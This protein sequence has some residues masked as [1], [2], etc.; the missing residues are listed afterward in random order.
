MVSALAAPPPHSSSSLRY[1]HCSLLPSLR[2]ALKRQFGETSLCKTLSSWHSLLRFPVRHSSEHQGNTSRFCSPSVSRAPRA[3]CQHSPGQV[4]NVQLR[5]GE[6]ALHRGSLGLKQERM[7]GFS[8]INAY[9][10]PAP[11]Y[12]NSSNK[13]TEM[14]AGFST[15]THH[16]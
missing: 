10:L 15:Q 12:E 1:T 16:F 7:P 2:S 8:Y 3:P 6:G 13:S 9:I 4:V 5:A 14:S 11:G